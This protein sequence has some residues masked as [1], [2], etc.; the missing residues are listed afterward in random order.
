MTQPLSMGCKEILLW[1]LIYA[2]ICSVLSQVLILIA[3]LFIINVNILHPLIWIVSTLS[4]LTSLNTWLFL[5]PLGSII[6]AQGIICSKDYVFET[7]YRTNRIMKFLGAFSIR[8]LIILSLHI[9]T[10]V[11]I[12]WMYLNLLGE[13][14]GSLYTQCKLNQYCLIEETFFMLLNGLWIGVFYFTK[15]YISE[16]KNIQ[17]P[18]IQQKSFLSVHLGAKLKQAMKNAIWPTVYFLVIYYYRGT[19]LRQWF[20][21]IFNLSLDK[22]PLSLYDMCS[23]LLLLYSWMFSTLFIFTMLS[24][25]LFFEVFLTEHWKFAI[26]SEF[27]FMLTLKEAIGMSNIPII[28]H[29]G[30]LDLYM[31]SL[32]DPIRRQQLFTLSQPGGHPH[33]WN[34]LLQEVLKLIADFSFE[35]NKATDII[36]TPEPIIKPK[37]NDIQQTFHDVPQAVYNETIVGSP[38]R[39]PLRNMSLCRPEPV[40]IV[41]VTQNVYLTNFIDKFKFFTFDRFSHLMVAIKKK[42]GLDYFLGDLPESR[43]YFLFAKGQPL[44]WAIQGLSIVVA[45]SF[46]EDKYGVVQK[47]LPVIITSLVNLKQNLDKLNKI[48]ILNRKNTQSDVCKMQ[49]KIALRTAVKRSLYNICNVFGEYLGHIP[50]S[51]EINQQVQNFVLCKEG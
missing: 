24:M 1:R 18:V 32:W 47:D 42:T 51:K 4:T 5:I 23:S 36:T 11:L 13:T 15:Q 37:E 3:F 45:A 12:V 28:Q 10:G 50:L 44:I 2:V 16:E 48:T 22:Q 25:K 38:F 30:C 26:E 20:T 40:D 17:F 9:V 6:F 8:N 49:S 21:S 35:I 14:H 27:D 46:T 19:Y 33:N 29:L 34:N 31:L 7:S 43:I 39:S 41:N